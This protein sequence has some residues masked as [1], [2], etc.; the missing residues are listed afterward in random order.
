MNILITGGAGFLAKELRAY[1]RTSTLRTK[2][3]TPDR[4][5]L[6]ILDRSALNYF[7]IE[8]KVDVIIH[9]AF[10]GTSKNDTLTNFVENMAMF[11]NLRLL[12]ER[13]SNT[14]LFNFCSD[15]K[16]VV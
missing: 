10:S 3:L 2:V 9:T 4:A 14:R 12:K 6:N 1:F 8:Q 7:F 11:N 16:S 13:F 15:R 5:Q